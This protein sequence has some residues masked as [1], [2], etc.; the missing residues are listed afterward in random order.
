MKA[1]KQDALVSRAGVVAF[2]VTDGP[3]PNWL[4][5][6]IVTIYDVSSSNIVITSDISSA[7]TSAD[8]SLI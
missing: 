7:S 2:V 5:A 1:Q 3:T 8:V 6:T 4:T